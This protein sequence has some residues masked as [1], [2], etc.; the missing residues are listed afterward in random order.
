M[1][2]E[3]SV[4]RRNVRPPPRLLVVRPDSEAARLR[5]RV[6]LLRC[7][8]NEDITHMLTGG[9]AQSV[10]GNQ[11]TFKKL[12]ITSTSHQLG[13]TLFSLRFELVTALSSDVLCAR[14]FVVVPQ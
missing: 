1:L 8:S 5:V 3:A 11:I 10:D 6:A 12:K 13:D 7:D 9:D 2:G 4:Y 14:V